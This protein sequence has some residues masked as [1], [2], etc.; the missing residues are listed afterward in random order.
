MP[1]RFTDSE[2]YRKPFIRSLPG[3]YKLLWDYICSDCNHAGIWLVDFEIAQ[4]CVG[5]DMPVGKDKALRLFNEGELRIL[6]LENGKKRFIISFIAFQYGKLS[7]SN[8]A[9]KN[10][11]LELKKF[12]LIDNNLDLL[13]E[14]NIN[15]IKEPKEEHQSPFEGAK[16]MVK[17]KEKDIKG[18]VG[19]NL[20][21]EKV[22]FAEFVSMTNDEYQSLV[23]K[24][25][26]N[27]ATEFIKILDN[28]KGSNGKKYKSDYRAILT[29][30]VDRFNERNSKLPNNQ[31]PNDN[32]EP[33]KII[34]R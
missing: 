8:P 9:H 20:K 1:K 23:A 2:K 24:Y 11:I 22:Q 7:Q 26:E 25:G 27:A 16:E 13:K 17:E 5:K 18:G 30:V 28:Y 12:G 33:E 14:F 10:I 4:I 34:C 32:E 21:K 15:I 31:K 3:A 29:W 19:E 6:E